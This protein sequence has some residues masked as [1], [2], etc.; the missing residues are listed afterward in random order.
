MSIGD[1]KRKARSVSMG[2]R[3]GSANNVEAVTAN[4]DANS[5][6]QANE[7]GSGLFLCIEDLVN[8]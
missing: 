8:A 7:G 2:G 5:D 1:R 3:K 4:A 6:T